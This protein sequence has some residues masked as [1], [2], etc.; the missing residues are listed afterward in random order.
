MSDDTLF[1]T[2]VCCLHRLEK[3]TKILPES[4]RWVPHVSGIENKPHRTRN[5]TADKINFSNQLFLYFPLL[6]FMI[7]YRRRYYIFAEDDGC[8]WTEKPGSE[9]TQL[10]LL[11]VMHALILLIYHSSNTLLLLILSYSISLI[12]LIF[13]IIWSWVCMWHQTAALHWQTR[14]MIDVLKNNLV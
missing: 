6:I 10:L 13:A 3:Q 1:S 2:C 14:W 7:L 11:H 9:H 12:I 5:P 8:R 4:C